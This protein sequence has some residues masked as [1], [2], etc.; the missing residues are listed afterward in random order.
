MNTKDLECRLAQAQLARYVSGEDLAAELVADLEAHLAECAE[1]HAAVEARR[2]VL[3]QRL[4]RR[5]TSATQVQ[6]GSRPEDPTEPYAAVEMVSEPRR[7]GGW[8]QSLVEVLFQPSSPTASGGSARKWRPLALSLLLS[9]LLIAMTAMAKNPNSL[10]GERVAPTA[11]IGEQ[12]PAGSS[13]DG[14]LMPMASGSSSATEG[15]PTSS[16]PNPDNDAPSGRNS[17]PADAPSG[18]EPT[19][20][21]TGAGLPREA[22]AGSGNRPTSA[23]GTRTKE[24]NAPPSPHPTTRP[25]S[26]PSPARNTVRPR[27]GARPDVGSIRVYDSNGNPIRP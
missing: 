22:E 17:P 19:K 1:C 4:F 24:A 6:T 18:D 10:F 13:S 8:L 2:S 14:R 3:A 21:E 12:S 15:P 27:V 16:A 23:T 5:E 7:R 11:A 25:S 26:V 9:G 20:A